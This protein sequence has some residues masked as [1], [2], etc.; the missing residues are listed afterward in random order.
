MIG[1]SKQ[2]WNLAILKGAT[3]S[4]ALHEVE[5]E[6]QGLL[7]VVPGIIWSPWK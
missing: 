7:H 2:V 1:T 4:R 6:R 3:S 5:P